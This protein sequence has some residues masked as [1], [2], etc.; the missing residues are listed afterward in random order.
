MRRLLR[1]GKHITSYMPR[2]PLTTGD[3]EH[4]RAALLCGLG[5]S[6]A[7]KWLVTEEIRTGQVQVLLPKLQPDRVPVH[8]VYPAGRRLPMRVR[9]LID[10]LVA[11]FER[12]EA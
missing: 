2:G 12:R 9:V 1:V 7:P 10:Y 8:L 11:A 6:Q 5:I 4:V 3:A